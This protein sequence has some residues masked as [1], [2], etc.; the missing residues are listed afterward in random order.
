MYDPTNPL[1]PVSRTR[2]NSGVRVAVGDAETRVRV[3]F[4]VEL[5][6]DRG[7]VAGDEGVV[8]RFDDNSLRGAEFDDASV[9]VLD[10]E[11]S[12][13]EEPHVRVLAEFGAEEWLHVGGPAETRRIDDPLH[14]CGADRHDVDGCAAEILMLGTFDGVQ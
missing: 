11:T 12:S 4:E 1:P 6:E 8:S 5:D 3:S 13:R 10:L 2:T 14:P 9:G 7:F